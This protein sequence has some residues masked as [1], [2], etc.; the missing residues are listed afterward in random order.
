MKEVKTMSN[1][2]TFFSNVKGA[3]SRWF[4]YKH[5]YI[6]TILTLIASVLYTSTMPTHIRAIRPLFANISGFYMFVLMMI[7]VVQIFN[8]MAFSKKRSPIS[9][10]MITVIA[11]LNAYV[12][13]K[14]I[15]TITEEITRRGISYTPFMMQSMIIV[16]VGALL[17]IAA[18]VYGWFIVNWKYV[19][20]LDE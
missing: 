12:A 16:A 11:S 18:V 3:I 8:S 6:T 1:K 7:A 20:P 9:L 17:F 4:E 5:Q 2:K 15:T 19:K 10:F 13:F 14:Y